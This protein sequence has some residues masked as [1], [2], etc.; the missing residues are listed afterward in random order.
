[1]PNT[2]AEPDTILD[3]L[4]D[5]F[6]TVGYEGATLSKLSEATGLQRA[7]LYHRFPGGKQDMAEAVLERAGEWF[8]CHILEPLSGT[9]APRARLEGMAKKLSAF[10]E[11][12]EASCL[13]DTLSFGDGRDIFETHIEGAFSAWIESIAALVGD[14]T[15]CSKS[16]ARRRAEDAVIRVQGALVL[17]R[18]TGDTKPF[19]RVLRTLPDALLGKGDE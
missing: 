15:H 7:S 10:Y 8:A 4:T 19:Q 2:K 3:R 13:L 11:R 17:A 12:G 18:G 14:A 16:I 9:G 6:R 1:M 5:V